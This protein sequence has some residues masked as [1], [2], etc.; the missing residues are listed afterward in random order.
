MAKRGYRGKHPY[1]DMKVGP[2]KD[3]A[4][5]KSKLRKEYNK[6]PQKMKYDYIKNH[7]G[8]A[9]ATQAVG[10][11][12]FSGTAANSKAITITSTD[13]T[14]KTYTSGNTEACP[15]WKRS[16]DMSGSLANCIN[17]GS[18]GHGG[19]ILATVTAGKVTLTQV[20]PGPDGNT[21]IVSPAGGISNTTSASFTGG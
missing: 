16:V 20:E 15:Q 8:W 18:I 17:S 7:E 10:S 13:G 6:T 1:N 21:T 11:L 2:T 12:T 9:A 5:N 19:K 3:K 14:E 4:A